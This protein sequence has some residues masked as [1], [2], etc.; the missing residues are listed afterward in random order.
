MARDWIDDKSLENN[1]LVDGIL[2]SQSK[3]KREV[4]VEGGVRS[5]E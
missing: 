3:D 2:C 4:G 1:S 5:E